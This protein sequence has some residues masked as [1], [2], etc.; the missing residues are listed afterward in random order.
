M[1]K[2]IQML[3]LLLCIILVASMCFL[4]KQIN[5]TT[6][7]SI[8][9]ATHAETDD[10]AL[11]N[12]NQA[13]MDQLCSLPGI[14]QKLAQNIIAYRNEIGTFRDYSELLNVEGIG[15]GRLEKILAYITLGG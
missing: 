10:S 3:L 9:L 4:H 7:L 14:G 5:T 12:I 11:I 8:S 1:K 13:D 15:Q 6:G 2:P